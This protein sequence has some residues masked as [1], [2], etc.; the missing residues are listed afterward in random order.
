MRLLSVDLLDDVGSVVLAD[1]SEGMI[2]MAR[3]RIEA[4]G[5]VDATAIVFDFPSDEPPP[6]A[7]FDLAV[8]LLVLH[9]V[10]DTAATLR[11]VREALVP[12]KPRRKTKPTRASKEKRLSEKKRR[13]EI[14]K[15]RGKPAGD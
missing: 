7:P 15:G 3:R 4:E 11:S 2:E 1:P 9:H 6:G 14:K 8:S 13:A 12:P 5:L 10:E